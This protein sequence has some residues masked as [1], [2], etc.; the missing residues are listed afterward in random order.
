MEHL[1]S[2]FP[3]DGDVLAVAQEVQRT[4]KKASRLDK[5][6][7]I[8]SRFAGRAGLKQTTS[9]LRQV[10]GVKLVN[11]TPHAINIIVGGETISIPPSGVVARVNTS[12][13]DC[14]FLMNDGVEIP[15]VQT[16]FDGEPEGIPAEE[17]GVFYLV[18][19]LVFEASCRSDL[20]APGPLVRN[21]KGQP[22]GCLGLS[23]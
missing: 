8:R 17:D 7:A 12:E 21:D 23:I 6:K 4:M 3:S 16:H 14:G 9:A 15:I 20:L 22:I 18:S 2:S 5:V 10:E 1:P 13:E 11:L 19:R